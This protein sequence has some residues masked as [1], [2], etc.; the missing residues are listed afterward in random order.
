MKEPA[1]RIF[2]S[3]V[4]ILGYFTIS[5]K[6]Q[7][8]SKVS[9]DAKDSYVFIFLCA[10]QVILN[11]KSPFGLCIIRPILL[12]S[13]AYTLSVNKGHERSK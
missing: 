7:M 4:G 6:Y 2:C 1:R 10:C 8:I 3:C 12:S 5:R 9:V 13:H 11:I